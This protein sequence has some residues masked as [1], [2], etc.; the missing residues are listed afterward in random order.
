MV[1][2]RHEVEDGREVEQSVLTA[3]QTG[4]K[5]LDTAEAYYNEEVLERQSK[6]A[7]Y[8]ERNYL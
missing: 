7:A 5:S 1:R 8:Q 4:Y 2:A 3:I 6:R